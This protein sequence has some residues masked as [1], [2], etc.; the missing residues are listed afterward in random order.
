MGARFRLKS[1]FDTSRFGP[2]ARVVLAAMQTYGLILADNGSNWFFQG[3]DDPGWAAPQY[4]T[5]ISQLKGVPATAFEAVDE[6]SLMVSANSDQAHQPS[7]AP[8]PAPPPGTPAPKPT[9]TAVTTPP[10]GTP[11]PT[12]GGTPVPVVSTPTSSSQP[13][14]KPPPRKGPGCGPLWAPIR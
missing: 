9:A 3:T 11:T 14:V 7:G 1:S 10:P 2:E 12:P 6:S 5:M 8:V 4:D 13:A